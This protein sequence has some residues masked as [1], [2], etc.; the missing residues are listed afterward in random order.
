MA[1]SSLF[2]KVFTRRFRPKGLPTRL[3]LLFVLAGGWSC[4]S[5]PMPEIRRAYAS[6]NFQRA[7]EMLASLEKRDPSNAHL[8][9]MERSLP[10]LAMARPAEA[11]K[12]LRNARDRLDELTGKGAWEWFSSMLLDDRQN[13]Y[14]GAD[15]EKVLVRALLSVSN[16]MRGGQ[17]ADA[18]AYQVLEKQLEIMGSFEAPNGKKPKKAY[19]L[20]AFGSY[21]R[22][23]LNSDDAMHLEIAKSAF[24]R[25]LEIE[26]ENPLIRRALDRVENGKHSRKGNGVVHVLAFVGRGPYRVEVDAPVTALAFQIAQIV[27]QHNRRTGAIPNLTRVPIPALAFH[28]DNPETVGIRVDGR[29]VGEALTVTD[30]EL[31]AEKEFAAMKDYI[32]SR[33]VLRR[34]FKL[35]VVETAKEVNRKSRGREKNLGLNLGLDLLGMLWTGAEA[36]DLRCWSFVPARLQAFRIELPAGVHEISLEPLG[37]GGLHGGARRVRVRVRDG[38]N[39][40]VLGLFPSWIGAVP[41]TSDPAEELP[42]ARSDSRISPASNSSASNSSASNSSASSLKKANK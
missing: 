8:Y 17:D 36:A 26:P 21:L 3:A 37:K 25:A 20:V 7:S 19:K 9:G 42:P 16:L 23:I 11:E 4:S 14:E 12:E 35:A 33:A 39:T 2:S 18:Y 10:L 28:Q 24:K 6:G 5:S 29:P 27:W 38:F 30:V 31:C 22:G 32:L 15:Y 1:P 41:L 40:Y 13:D 34:A